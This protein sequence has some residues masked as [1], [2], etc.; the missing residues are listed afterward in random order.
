MLYR[1]II[2][3]E[4]NGYIF[5]NQNF[6]LHFSKSGE[7]NSVEFGEKV[8]TLDK[9]ELKFTLNG[10]YRS[11]LEYGKLNKNWAYL[12]LENATEDEFHSE[13]LSHKL[14]KTHDSVELHLCVLLKNDSNLF[15]VTKIYRMSSNRNGFSR[16]FEI[17]NLGET[18]VIRKVFVNFPKP[19]GFEP[20]VRAAQPSF[21]TNGE[22]TLAAWRDPRIE[23]HS[24]DAEL[25]CVVAV[26]N[27]LEKCELLKFGGIEYELF[28]ENSLNAAK[29]VK[30][31]LENIG[32]RAHRENE[33]VLRSLVCYE[34]EIGPL[35]LSETKCHHRYDHPCE[36]ATDLERIKS[37]GFN[38]IELMPS[39]LFPCYTVYDLKNPDIQH[40]AGESIRP[41]I[42]R[43]HELGMR[44]IIDVLMHGCIDTEIADFDKEHYSSRRYYWTEW[45]KKIPELVGRERGR[46]NPLRE[47]HP[48]WFIY[49][50]PDKIFKGYTWT[51]DHANP[52]FQEYF[53]EAME[54]SVRDWNVDGFRFDAPTWQSGVNSANN[55]PY[56]AGESLNRGNCELFGKTRER[57]DSVKSGV[58]FIVET[59][60][61][62][63]SDN[64]DMGYSYD[65]Y[66]KMKNIIEN[67]LNISQIQKYCEMKQ[68]IYPNGAVCL[69]FAD[70]HDTWNNG[71]VEDG[72]YS[73]E[74]FGMDAAKALFAMACFMD[75]GVQAFG[76]SE[77]NKE[78]GEFMKNALTKRKELPKFLEETANY[79][80]YPSD[81][82][83]LCIVRKNGAGDI[84]SF[85]VN[86]SNT[87][88]DCEID[89]VGKVRF[90]PYEPRLWLNGEKTEFIH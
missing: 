83:V 47:E 14:V 55:L 48:D 1:D 59:P 58:L 60:Y 4:N 25:N 51:F 79:S 34:V 66:F 84:L 18:A 37:L 12:K 5:G 6:K 65:I 41:V 53:A 69:N 44:V 36:L 73:F 76:G 20:A 52:E 33:K 29:K 87:E 88:V 72:L 31:R 85:A 40:G 64:C 19:V 22:Q 3:E 50:T 7:L 45:Q 27:S 35:K 86:F 9:H 74:R 39:F 71:V 81:E 61:Y 63:Y 75:G 38:T 32:F 70:N 80:V 26:Q 21:V 42:D 90:N 67:H 10:E 8:Y 43:A 78:F 57:I 82:K 11:S 28:N 54:I 16:D 77:D 23:N 49:E 15:E 2:F 68:K 17:K 62:E 13:Y 89:G 46:V 24:F 30:Y 56:S